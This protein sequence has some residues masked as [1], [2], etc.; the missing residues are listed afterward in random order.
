MRDENVVPKLYG[1]RLLWVYNVGMYSLRDEHQMSR[2]S[3]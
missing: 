3:Y 2:L 1:D